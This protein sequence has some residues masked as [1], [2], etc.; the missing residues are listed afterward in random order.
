MSS[1]A[2]AADLRTSSSLRQIVIASGVAATLLGT[3]CIAALPFEPTIVMVSALLWLLT[4]LREI[5]ALRR[6]YAAF[7]HL[8]IEAGG[9]VTLCGTTDGPI[10]ADLLPGSVVLR[11]VAWLHLKAANG[12]RFGELIVGNCR[13]NKDWRRLQVIWR[14]P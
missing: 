13:K 4:S 1:R 8:R 9:A 6:A 7:S 10:P 5:V 2:Y 3:L 12:L 11:R 14:H